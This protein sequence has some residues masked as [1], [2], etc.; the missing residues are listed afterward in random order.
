[1]LSTV[2]TLPESVMFSREQQCSAGQHSGGPTR[3]FEQEVSSLTLLI[4][5]VTVTFV[6]FKGQKARKSNG[7]L[8][9]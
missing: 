8:D 2:S 4:P 7:G 5:E 3:H 1:M 9:Y 6:L